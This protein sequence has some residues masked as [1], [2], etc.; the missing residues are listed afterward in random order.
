MKDEENY[1]ILRKWEKE[2]E[3]DDVVLK[4]YYNIWRYYSNS[5]NV[6]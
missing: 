1:E 6:K 2:F 4:C 5:D 3:V